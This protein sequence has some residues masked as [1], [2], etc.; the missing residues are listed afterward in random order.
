MRLQTAPCGHLAFD[1][2]RHIVNINDEAL[3]QL[4]YQRR[5]L[6]GQ[7]LNKLLPPA[8][9][10]LF[11]ANIFPLLAE[12]GRAEE[13]YAMLRCENGEELPVLLNAARIRQEHGFLTNCVFLAVK[14]RALFERHLERLEA[15]RDAQKARDDAA[16]SS[17]DA[18]NR[19]LSERLSTL[20]LLLA[21]IM[22][23]VRNPLT[24]VQGNLELLEAELGEEG[25]IDCQA[26]RECLDEA[27]NGVTRIR[28]LVSA[29]S[30][31]S[32]TGG[33]ELVLVNTA[34]VVDTAIKLVH[35]RLLRWAKVQVEGP[36]PGASVPADEARLVQVVMNLLVNAGQ[37]LQEARPSDARIV[38]RNFVAQESAVIEVADNGPGVPAAVRE[39]IF[40]PFFTTKPVGEGTG[41]GLAISRQI[42]CSLGGKLELRESPG[43]G[44]TFHIELP[45]PQ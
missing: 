11:Q 37:A 32:R 16:D 43:G 35:H 8:V 9:R 21:G 33:A 1:D 5:E 20:G 22:H 25:T 26:V 7:S 23:E 42:V 27:R 31:V 40:E 36:R 13:V 39:R 6:V 38:V 24:Y 18:A 12:V 45:L 17:R 28:D 3:R 19:E 2:E 34:H 29:V 14:R 44:A 41:L 15:A 30:L 4:G 10:I